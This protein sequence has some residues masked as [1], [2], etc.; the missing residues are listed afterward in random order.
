VIHYH[1]AHLVDPSPW[2]LL[3][4]INLGFITVGGAAYLHYYPSG[5]PTLVLGLA[6][7]AVT[8]GYWWRDVIREGTYNRHHTPVVQKNLRLGM[9][10]FI[11]SEVMFFFSFF[12]A[13]FHSSLA[14]THVIGCVWPPAAISVISPF[15]I[16]LWNTVLLLSSGATITLAHYV[17][18]NETEHSYTVVAR[19]ALHELI[20][21]YPYEEYEVKTNWVRFG[22][23]GTL[24]CGV[25]FIGLQFCEYLWAP[26]SISDSIYGSVFFVITGFHGLHVIIGSIF[27]IV[28]FV[29]YELSH[30]TKKNH[31][32]FEAAAWY[33]HFV[34][35]VWLLVFLSI[36]YWSF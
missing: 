34:D 36:Y 16:P 4:A 10:L 12:W 30:F 27:I 11:V 35:V 20:V 6:G 5:I 23:I 1:K 9:V 2:P 28:G 13:F 15:G 7:L 19:R 26:F 21:G 17:L 33:W 18:S 31:F 32:G 3:A 29:R 25:A 14:P 8:L 24:L 22:F